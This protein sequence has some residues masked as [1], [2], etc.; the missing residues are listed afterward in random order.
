MEVQYNPNSINIS[1]SAGSQ[2]RRPATGDAAA[3]QV[4]I[5]ANMV[6]SALTVDLVFEDINVAD[7]FHMEG[8]DMNAESLM[9]TVASLAF[10]T[11]GDGYS[12]KKPCE[13]LMA[14]L[15]FKKLKQVI[16]LWS[17]MFFHGELT[18]V[19][20]RYEMFNKLGNPILATVR[21]TIEQ[22]DTQ[23]SIHYSSDD[24]QWETAFDSAFGEAGT[25]MITKMF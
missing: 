7:A 1:N 20:V 19:D 6:R 14:L 10:N 18:G 4:S 16:F 22:N 15:N 17:D 11:F 24:D 12:V 5:S 23:G 21:L 2:Y 9:Q 13:G 25:S 8:L 3:T